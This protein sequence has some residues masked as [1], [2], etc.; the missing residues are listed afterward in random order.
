MLSL[1]STLRRLGRGLTAET[2]NLSALIAVANQ[3]LIPTVPITLATSRVPNRPRFTSLRTGHSTYRRH[4][5][6]WMD[7][8]IEH[9]GNVGYRR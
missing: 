6:C 8:E 3:S 4:Q 1:I 2:A 5:V 7:R 9:Q